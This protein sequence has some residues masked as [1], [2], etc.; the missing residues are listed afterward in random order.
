[1]EKY[2]LRISFL[3][4]CDASHLA[5]GL[6][7]LQLTTL[8]A[9]SLWKED[10]APT[11]MFADKK[12]QRVGDI[13]TVVIQENNGTSRN[14]NTTTSRT[15]AVDASI[16]S[17][18]YPPGVSGLLTKG[19]QLPAMSLSGK[20][21]FNGG[22]QIANQETIIAQIAVKVIDV[23]PNGNL[24]VEGR[25]QTAFSGEKQEAVLRGT[26]RADD[27]TSTNTVF[28]YNIADASIQYISHGAITDSQNKGWFT[29]V[30]DKVSPF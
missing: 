10:A 14:N 21:S 8:G 13:V 6:F 15:S 28:S 11:S 4:R 22:G 1:M 16:S 19:G 7:L 17:F 5:V 23:L 9:D 27:V 26:L 20:N 12:A 18:L 3:S 2:K 29:K 25:R 24:V 30:W